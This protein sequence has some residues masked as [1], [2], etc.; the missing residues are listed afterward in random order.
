LEQEG[1]EKDST[2]K[3][4]V[5]SAVPTNVTGEGLLLLHHKEIRWSRSSYVPFTTLEEYYKRGLKLNKQVSALILN[6]T[7]FNSCCLFI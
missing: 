4:E 3:V 7:H 5:M 6:C 1:F 2:I